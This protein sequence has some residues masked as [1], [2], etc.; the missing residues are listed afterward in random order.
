MEE[1]YMTATFQ[2]YLI[3]WL[4]HKFDEFVINLGHL[5]IC[6]T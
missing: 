6:M 5:F 3:L 1:K 2:N 4:N